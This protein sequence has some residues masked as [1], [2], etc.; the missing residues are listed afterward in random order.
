LGSKYVVAV[1]VCVRDSANTIQETINCLLR[2]DFPHESMEVVFVDDGSKDKTLQILRD[3]IPK[4]DMQVKLFHHD[5]KG[6]GG[7]RN[8]VIRNADSEYILWVDGDMSF[9]SD[10]VTNLVKFMNANPQIGIAKGKQSL[11]S[12]TNLLSTLET[13]SRAVGRMVNYD[14]RKAVSKSLGTGGAIYR[15]KVFEK[16]GLFDEGLRG[17]GEDWD[18]EV[19][20]RKAGWSL[21]V[22]EAE[23]SDHERYGI[24]W[25]SLW[26]RYWRRGYYAHYFLHK[27]KGYL[28]LYNMFPAVAFAV[29]FIHA[30]K[31]F[32]ATRRKVSFLLPLEYFF[33][34]FAWY[35]GYLDSHALRYQ[36][37]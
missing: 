20:I 4:M 29:G 31:L 12:S 10:F 9:S 34:M 25:R 17:Y 21:A 6:L 37:R 19:R 24:T 3:N 8:V 33:K 28:K 26:A 30:Y 5:W 11:K 14:S 36:P 2:Q 32:I 35:V 22:I 27:N 15:V 23:F 1:G 7:S 16:V 13:G 18:I